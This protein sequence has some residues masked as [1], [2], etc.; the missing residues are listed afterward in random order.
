MP[1]KTNVTSSDID[2]LSISN[3]HAESQRFWAHI[4][5]AYGFTFWTCYVLLKEYGKVALMR[6]QFLAYEKRRAD[7]FTVLARNIPPDPDESINP[8]VH[9]QLIL[10]C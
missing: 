1:R 4:V 7:Q 10:F 9:L 3:V 5:V 6:L 8:S 2:E